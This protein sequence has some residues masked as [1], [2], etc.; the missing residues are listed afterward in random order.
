MLRFVCSSLFGGGIIYPS[1][2]KW[3]MGPRIRL[4]SFEAQ[5]V[6]WM[7]RSI[8][9][10]LPE[11][12]GDPIESSGSLPSNCFFFRGPKPGFIQPS[13]SQV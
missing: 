11:S 4:R 13:H 12:D 5:E 1:K 6:S 3:L 8:L 9:I 10:L 7:W 2:T